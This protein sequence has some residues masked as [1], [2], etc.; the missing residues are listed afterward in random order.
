MDRLVTGSMGKILGQAIFGSEQAVFEQVEK[1]IDDLVAN[2]VDWSACAAKEQLQAAREGKLGLRFFD[3]DVPEEW[4]KDVRGKRVLC[5]AGAGGLQAPL[6]ACA[7]AEVTVID[8][9]DKMLDKDREVAERE[10]LRIEIVK[11]NMC[12]LYCLTISLAVKPDCITLTGSF[13]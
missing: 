2:S 13:A 5:L 9:S 1:N 4:L 12:D 3:R 8:I 7:G 6:L 10:N 11:G